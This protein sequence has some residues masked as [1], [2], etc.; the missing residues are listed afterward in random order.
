[1]KLLKSALPLVLSLLLVTLLSAPALAL[2]DELP[3]EQE[4][5]PVTV[6]TLEELLT[7]IESAENGDTI[8][9]QNEIVI[10]KNCTI[11]HEGKRITIIPAS[12]FDGDTMLVIWPYEEQN[13]IFQ[14]VALDGQN[15]SALSAIEANFWGTI[16]AERTIRLIGVQVKNFISN[17]SNVYFSA[18]HI[19][20]ND[21]QFLDNMAER[22]AGIEIAS[23]AT[24][25]ISDCIFSGNTLLSN[26]GALLCRGQ[27]QIDRTTITQNQAI[28]PNSARLGGGIYIDY[29]AFCEISNC[30][31]TDNISVLGGGVATMG[32]V[33][34]MDTFLCKNQG[35]NGANDI[36]TF[37]SGEC[38]VTYSDEMKSVYLE[39]NP[40]G[41]YLDDMDNRFNPE[42]NAVFLGESLDGNTP[43]NQY[44]ARFIFSSDLPQ[45][46]PEESENPGEQ[47]PPIE[48]PTES[49]EPD[50]PDTSELPAISFGPGEDII[51]PSLP[52]R[53]FQPIIQKPPVIQEE[54]P[55]TQ[56]EPP[57]LVLSRGG[58]TLDTTIPFVLLG[59][60]D[61][62]LHEND[63]ITRAQIV[64]LLYRS[65]TDGSKS[66]IADTSLF[67]DVASGA[68]YY[69]AVTV[70][71][72]AGIINGCDGLFL[73]N[74]T[75]TY[76]Q[77][78]AI[79]TRFV[80][81]KEAPMLDSLP[82]TGHWAHSNIVTAVA[83]GW[84]DNA[85]GIEPDRT[86]TRGEAVEIVN[87]IF[88]KI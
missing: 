29:Q 75:L 68:W 28:D 12:N 19:I 23:N 59:Y 27:T 85:T 46:P 52:V 54:Q 13:I 48:L 84:I 26:G 62:Q 2:D 8:I 35:I 83:Y 40:V 6:C 71:A 64:V 22:T 14:N 44:G 81:P 45:S 50:M 70:L 1:M 55:L 80:E 47:E 77:L 36:M 3:K 37:S 18:A 16:N 4:T 58:V 31:I 72:S 63:P 78:I 69:D 17:Y 65:L 74:D 57:K 21:C 67:A 20:A 9:L 79:L 42:S 11:G 87:S 60:G 32:E 76:G 38:T 25:K 66:S 82:Y 41:F 56:E 15:K 51:I 53:P 43:M 86:I 10:A 73:P 7:A 33:S 30:Q 61:G 88:E 34:I 24:A 5:A 39:N 49:Q